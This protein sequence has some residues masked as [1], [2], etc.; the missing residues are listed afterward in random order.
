MDSLF[1]VLLEKDLNQKFVTV[2]D[3]S[4]E[5][6][7]YE[8]INDDDYIF[9]VCHGFSDDKDCIDM[10]L[11]ERQ[12]YSIIKNVFYEKDVIYEELLQV[13]LAKKNFD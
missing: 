9:L 1:W 10:F 13:L 6:F 2:G 3:S 8:L 11:A 5:Y 12:N 4:D 7:K